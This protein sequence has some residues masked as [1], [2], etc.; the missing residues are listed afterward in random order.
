MYDNSVLHNNILYLTRLPCY[1]GFMIKKVVSK[2]SLNDWSKIKDDL[3]YWLSKTPQ[4]RIE[5]MEFLR[6]QYYGDSTGLQRTVRVI[7][8]S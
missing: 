4:Q 6:R 2:C 1:D 7:K 3:K 5:A 8:R